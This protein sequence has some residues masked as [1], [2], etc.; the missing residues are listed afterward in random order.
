MVA[1][2]LEEEIIYFNDV[3]IKEIKHIKITRRITLI[4]DLRTLLY[5]C[6]YF[7][8]MKFDVVHTI[9]AKAGLLGILASS[10]VGIPNCIH[11]FTGQVCAV[12]SVFINIFNAFRSIYSLECNPYS[13]R[14]TSAETVFNSE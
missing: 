11:I 14:W 10:F 2:V 9:T 12:K 5:L 3:P 4:N 13:G 1:N 6:S 8:K 7:K